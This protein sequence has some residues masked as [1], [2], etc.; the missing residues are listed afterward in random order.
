MSVHNAEKYLE[1]S[2]SSILDQ[3][4]SEFEFLIIDDASTDRSVE[5]VERQAKKD[6]RIRLIAN[7]KKRGLTSNLNSLLLLSK[8]KYIARMDADDISALNRLKTQ[9]EY[10]EQNPDVDI[11]GSYAQ[12]INENGVKIGF[13]HVPITHEKIEKLL[14]KLNPIS[15]PTVMF[16]RESIEKLHGYDERFST[17]QDYHLWFKAIAAGLEIH[18][19]PEYLLK[20][21]MN[22]NY[23]SRKSMKYR[24]NEFNIKL[25]GY[26]LMSYPWYKYYAALFSLV[27]AFMPS[28]IFSYIKRLDPR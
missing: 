4:F 7:K 3:S 18:N 2:I 28:C 21:R 17:S 14:P 15:H 23:K 8:K 27:L 26:R 10:L 12:N 1:E 6:D 9:Y 20:Y 19:I 5:I 24:L 11:V 25:E 16:R 22:D 13:R